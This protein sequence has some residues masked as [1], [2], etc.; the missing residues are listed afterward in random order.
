MAVRALGLIGDKTAV[1]EL[2][3]LV[4][5]FNQN[6]R[7]WAQISL[8]RLTGKNFG[9]DAGAWKRWWREQDGKPPV[10]EEPVVWMKD[11]EWASPEKQAEIDRQ[12][13]E[14]AKKASP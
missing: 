5:H 12:F 11:S 1:P 14:A 13:I 3:D 2:I 6:T 8:V 9:R 7:F 4:Y 10:S